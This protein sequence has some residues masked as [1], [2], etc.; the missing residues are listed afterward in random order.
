MNSSNYTGSN[1]SAQAFLMGSGFVAQA[2]LVIVI[3][4]LLFILMMTLETIY[5][6]WLRA[7]RTRI[8]ILPYSTNSE[9]KMK[10]IVQNPKAPNSLT[11]PLSE[12]ER[13][14]AEF[15]Y[16]F[17]IFI[18]PSNIDNNKTTTQGLRHVFHK[19]YSSYYPLM[20]PGV[21]V[22]TNENA[23]RVYM[24][25]SKSWD[26]H[27]DIPNIPLKKWVHIVIVGRKNTVEIYV[28][29]NIAKKI[30]FDGVLYQNYQDLI[31][32][33]QRSGRLPRS[34]SNAQQVEIKS[35]FSGSLSSLVYY[36]YAISYSE[37]QELMNEGPSSKTEE[38]VDGNP[39]AS[40]Y[41]VDSWWV[42]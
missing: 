39:N 10:T 1:N 7:S 17:Y 4:A 40:P 35:A 12:N 3:S 21:F 8:D 41:L 27:V 29:G 33:S 28:N 6:T 13:T 5:L 22:K 15:S 30:K 18:N 9:N 19:G 11:L 23:L 32:F 26:N 14:G 24:N 16:S 25:S 42:R 2:L 37:V 20:G 38:S 34:S 36:S 31:L